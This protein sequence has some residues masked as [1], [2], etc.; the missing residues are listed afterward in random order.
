MQFDIVGNIQAGDAR[1]VRYHDKRIGHAANRIEE[2]PIIPLRLACRKSVG[3][4]GLKTRRKDVGVKQNRAKSRLGQSQ[5]FGA[6]L[7]LALRI[8]DDCRR[9]RKCKS[10]QAPLQSPF[11]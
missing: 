1:L 10:P 4:L 9:A 6:K 8:D 2:C 5:V 7:S 11:P 3:S